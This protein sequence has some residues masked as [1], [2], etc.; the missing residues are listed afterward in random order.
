MGGMFAAHRSIHSTTKYSPFEIVYGFNPLTPLD[1]I[2]L[3]NDKLM[4]LDAKRKAEYVKQLH[5]K[6]HMRKER[7]PIQRRSKLLPRGDG[8]F[9]VLER[10]NENSYKLDLPGEY[11]ISASFNVSDLS[12][13]DVGDDLGKIA[14]KN[15][16]MIRPR[17]KTTLE[18]LW[19]LWSC[20]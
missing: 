18:L 7:F 15:E 14:S 9:Q 2:P 16:G 11:N 12:I 20:H 19:I 13:Y 3:P 1:L 6:V 17:P 4:N 8:P 5:Q 10:I